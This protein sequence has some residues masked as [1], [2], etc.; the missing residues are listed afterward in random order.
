MAV[1]RVTVIGELYRLSIGEDAAS[2]PMPA[3]EDE[4]KPAVSG[5]QVIGDFDD[6]LVGS[7]PE[8]LICW[9]KH[10]RQAVVS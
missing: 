5:T 4:A 2:Y 7:A 3:W 10:A 8:S 1:G 9:R 6:I